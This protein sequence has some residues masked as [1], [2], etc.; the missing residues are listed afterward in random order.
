MKSQVMSNFDCSGSGLIVRLFGF[1]A[2]MCHGKQ[3]KVQ[4]PQGPASSI[5]SWVPK[6][7]RLSIHFSI[8]IHKY[9]YTF[10]DP[11]FPRSH[12][13]YTFQHHGFS[14]SY[15]RYTFQDPGF[16]RSMTSINFRIQ[17]FQDPKIF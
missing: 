13:K 14:G 10:Q 2:D 12:V 16:P 4:D 3:I 5:G 15:V 8:S 17:S 7:P 9:K 11:G 6:A 1:D